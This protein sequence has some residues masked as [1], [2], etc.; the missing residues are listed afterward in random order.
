M[1]KEMITTTGSEMNEMNATPTFMLDPMKA[2]V[3]VEARRV[4][5]LLHCDTTKTVSADAYLRAVAIALVKAIVPAELITDS[6]V[7][8]GYVNRAVIV[9]EI[10]PKN[11]SAMRQAVYEAKKENTAPENDTLANIC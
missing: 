2:E 5:T 9:L 7:R 8:A 6:R 3:M 1:S 4:L 11:A 10:L